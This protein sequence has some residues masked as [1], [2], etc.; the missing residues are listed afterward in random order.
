MRLY[1]ETLIDK[2]T[3][4]KSCLN[5]LGLYWLYYKRFKS[6]TEGRVRSVGLG[7]IKLALAIV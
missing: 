7:R 3:E 5:R 2:S 4:E 6:A 1:V